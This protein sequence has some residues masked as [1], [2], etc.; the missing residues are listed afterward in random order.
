MKSFSSFITEKRRF[1]QPKPGKK[2]ARGLIG[3]GGSS[4]VG[5]SAGR[6]AIRQIAKV[7][8]KAAVHGLVGSTIGSIVGPHT[9]AL[10]GV[11]GIAHGGIT[12]TTKALK[13]VNTMMGAHSREKG[14]TIY[15]KHGKPFKR[16]GKYKE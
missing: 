3:P 6:K 16:T 5:N 2:G 15:P 14:N 12:G 11:L 7:V 13:S 9:A 8:P 10:G 4:E 1:L